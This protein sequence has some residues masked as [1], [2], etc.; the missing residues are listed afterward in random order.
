MFELI[1]EE[2]DS[3]MTGEGRFLEEEKE[4]A[5]VTEEREEL[6]PREL[7]KAVPLGAEA[8]VVKAVPLGAEAE[9]ASVT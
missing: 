1:V 4:E 9:I 5:G 8:E 7:V 6:D 3:S 2:G